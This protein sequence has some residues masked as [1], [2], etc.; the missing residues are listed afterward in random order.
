VL[1]DPVQLYTATPEIT[2]KTALDNAEVCANLTDCFGQSVWSG[3]NA[4]GSKN[5]SVTLPGC[6][7][8]LL[9]AQVTVNGKV[10]ETASTSLLVTAP[11]P[12]D[13]YA[14][15]VPAFG[16]W[17]GLDPYLRQVGGAKWDR[18][19]FFTLF[20]KADFAA[21]APDAATI[22]KREPVKIIRCLNVLNPFKKMV[23]VPADDWAD[24]LTKL[25]KEITSHRGL[26]DVW[27][28]QNEPMVG[29]NFHGTMAD[30]MDIIRHESAAVRR[31]DPGT[32][33]AGICINPMNQNQFNQYLGYYKQFEIERYIDGVMLHPYIPG[34]QSP[35]TSG[36][37]DVLN[38]LSRELTAVTGKHVPMYISEIGYSTKPGGE[39]TELQQAAYLARVML[40]NFQIPD[41]QACVWHIGLWN[42][43]TSQ[44]ELDFGLLRKYEKGSP[45]RQ[46]KPAYAAWATA[47]R[48]LYNAKY[49]GELNFNRKVRVLLFEKN[50]QP[51]LAAYSLLP[52]DVKFQ[53]AVNGREANLTQVCGKTMHQAIDDGVLEL[54]LTEAPVYIEA[55]SLDYFSGNQFQAEFTPA[56]WQIAAGAKLTAQIKI[57]ASQD[58]GDLTLQAV[59]PA[60]IM[61]GVTPLGGQR[62]ELAIIPG[63]NVK[64]GFYDLFL[65]LQAN[66]ENRYIWQKTLEITAPV[67]LGSMSS[68]AVDGNVFLTVSALSNTGKVEKATVEIIENNKRT[69]ALGEVKTGRTNSL[70]LHLPQSGW[71]NTYK[72]KI[73]LNDRQSWEQTLPDDLAPLYIAFNS[74]PAATPG[75]RLEDGHYSVHAVRGQYDQPEGT[76]KLSYDDE[77]LYLAVTVR[78]KTLKLS[79]RDSIWNSDSLQI[80]IS[81]PQKDM[82][83][84]NNDGIQETSYAEFAV[85]A[86][87]A[88]QNSQVYASMNLNLMP[89]HEPVPGLRSNSYYEGE[90]INYRLA[91]PWKTLNIVPRN[92]LKL[93]ISILVNDRDQGDRHWLE[94]YGGIAD[95]KDPSRYGNACLTK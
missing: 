20:Q 81:V 24:I 57:P 74:N 56:E 71:R 16:V 69:V 39:V 55:G 31:L 10:T 75:W 26:V 50:S 60:D 45:V 48:I 14:T 41:L 47:S 84:P 67:V 78:D 76:V 1:P 91:V 22:A 23:P 4:P 30:V 37:V 38:R 15:S 9:T 3:K 17:G 53:L 6:D 18:Q 8:Y 33:I 66:R 83:K 54:T 32:P 21:V 89:L 40:L 44:R 52:E 2:V 65:R 42:E 35:D 73:T 27:E 70:Q 80:G 95:G 5:L 59:A 87:A 11:L 7:Y 68:R 93:G 92:D 25:D 63:S 58:K 79:S 90:V 64:P 61:V 43:A 34:A 19:L 62:Y 82:I 51:L 72:A 12:K 49:V 13:Y 94:W 88:P 36:Y 85:N 77:F 29:E 46:P 86:A 28:T